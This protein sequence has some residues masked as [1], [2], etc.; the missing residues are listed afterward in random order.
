M[1]KTSIPENYLPPREFMP[2]NIRTLPELKYSQPLN[3]TETLLDQS[4]RAYG[5]RI[6]IYYEAERITYREVQARVNRFANALRQL[7]VG[8]GDRVALR[9]FN[10]P[11]YVVWNFACWR[12]G[13]VPVLVSHVNRAAE[14]AFKINDSEAMA[15]C[16]HVDNYPDLAK[17]R[18][19]CPHLKHVIAYGGHGH[20][21]GTLS[22]EDLVRGQDEA[23][24]SEEMRLEDIARIIYSSGTTGKPKGILS[25][26]EGML[27]GCDIAGRHVLKFTD[28]DVLGGH[29]SFSFAFGAGFLRMP[30]RFGMAISII[31]AFEPKRQLELVGEHGITILLA[32]PTAFRMMLET[33]RG[34]ESLRLP[35]V[36]IC[37]SAGEPLPSSTFIDWRN[38]FGT[39][40]INSLGSGELDYWLSTFEGM[41]EEKLGSA[42][43]SVPGCEN[44][45]VDDHLNPVPAG[46]PGELLVRGPI[47]QMYWR[48][49]DAQMKGVCPPDS[50]YAGWSRPGLYCMQDEDGYFWLKSR[51]DDMI[52][53]AGYKIPGG[54]VEAALNNHP[55]VLESAVVGVSDQERGSVIKAFVVLKEGI[56]PSDELARELQDFVKQEI[57]PY[58]YPRLIQFVA[59]DVLPRTATGKIQ[60]SE[61][62]NWKTQ[63]DT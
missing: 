5:D 45:I 8:K 23:T 44:I 42:G 36:R 14:L 33:A 46:T 48:R 35:S 20:I 11:E 6:A 2:R 58:K 54:E 57:E 40:I 16:V 62:R 28:T 10:I 13:A 37:Q 39:T 21:A 52:V 32:V 47:G 4:L 9:S 24:V 56:R 50:K 17:V 29:P 19:D 41:P 34:D 7:G 63:S 53:T 15:I 43:V 1:S 51:L 60:R 59:G 22:Y 18:N 30:W 27:S 12:I 61:L 31:P 26:V 38:R 3:L 55:S 25:T 49:P